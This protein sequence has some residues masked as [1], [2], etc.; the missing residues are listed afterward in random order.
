LWLWSLF[1]SIEVTLGAL[2]IR[3]GPWVSF[4]GSVLILVGAARERRTRAPLAG[5]EGASEDEQAIV[6][7]HAIVLVTLLS[8]VFVGPRALGPIGLAL[9]CAGVFDICTTVLSRMSGGRDS[10]QVAYGT[11]GAIEVLAG[12]A[13]LW[14][15]RFDIV[16]IVIGLVVIAPV[17]WYQFRNVELWQQLESEGVRDAPA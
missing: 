3:I 16:T 9:S 6:A 17:L 11:V 14:H 13:L 15:E 12:A 10:A 4:L 2:D 8:A 5:G 1:T 7:V